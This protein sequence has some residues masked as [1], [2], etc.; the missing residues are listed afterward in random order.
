MFPAQQESIRRWGAP[1]ALRV[2]PLVTL[3]TKIAKHVNLAAKFHDLKFGNLRSTK[4]SL[5]PS[6]PEI[7]R[8]DL[9]A[10][11]GTQPQRTRSLRSSVPP[12]EFP[13]ILKPSEGLQILKPSRWAQSSKSSAS[14]SEISRMK[15]ARAAGLRPSPSLKHVAVPSFSG[16]RDPQTGGSPV[17]VPSKPSKR[18]GTS[19]KKC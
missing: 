8:T 19:P 2:K 12:S 9:K 16:S 1:P 6:T 13:S 7:W 5:M 11:Q 18:G 14:P 15:P 4:C 3:R 17:D 10:P